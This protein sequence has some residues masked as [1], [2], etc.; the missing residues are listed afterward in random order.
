MSATG[1]GHG[2]TGQEPAAAGHQPLAVYIHLPFCLAKCAYCDFNSQVA[3][4]QLRSLY[5]Q[6]LEAELL[7]R[8]ADLQARAGAA[9]VTVTTVYLGGGTPTVYSP[10]QLARVLALVRETLTVAPD[11]EITCEANPGTVTEA[12]LAELCRAGVNRISIGVQSFNDAELK[13]LGRIHT[14]AEAM[15]AVEAARAAGFDN[16]SV[17]LIRGLPGQ[18]LEDWQRTVDTA[19][20]LG[21]DH[22]SCYG[23]SIEPRTPLGQRVQR[24]ELVPL[25]DDAAAELFIYTHRR[26]VAAGYEHYEISNFARPGKRCRHN[27]AYWHN[28][29]Y[30]GLGAGAWSYI[31]GE[32]FRNVPDPAGYCRAAL[33]GA[34]LVVESERLSPRAALGE[35][36]MLGLRLADGVDLDALS[37]RFGLDLRRL[38]RAALRQAVS[39]GLATLDGNRLRPTLR[40]MLLNNELAALFLP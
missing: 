33:E 9:E 16:L 6:A 12:S 10:R 25:D 13:L 1:A 8:A 36:M 17:D 40:G 26:L 20:T 30:L 27:L 34:R 24:G 29:P 11:A 4:P 3:D 5:L 37:M 35:T 39:A 32:R 23:L 18:S 22:L 21:P 19:L 28:Q 7:Q 31:A 2:S 15:Q 14:A 38:Y